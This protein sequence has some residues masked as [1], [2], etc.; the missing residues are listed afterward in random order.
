[1]I[2]AT[3]EEEIKAK[4]EHA[5]Q[6]AEDTLAARTAFLQMVGHELRTPLNAVL[7]P[8]SIASF[9]ND[10][11]ERQ[12]M[13]TVA[14]RSA[15]DL[16]ATV[17]ALEDFI[18]LEA[19][20]TKPKLEETDL[21]ELLELATIEAVN[22]ADAPCDVPI[23]FKAGTPN[24]A[25]CDPGIIKWVVKEIVTNALQHANPM[26][27]EER[28][29]QI[30]VSLDQSGNGEHIS[31]A[32][33]DNGQG[34]ADEEITSALQPF[35]RLGQLNTGKIRGLGIGLALAKRYAELLK[36]SLSYQHG[37]QGGSTF[38]ITLPV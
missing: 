5:K 13:I 17:S 30:N 6:V 28:K 26:G 22:Q 31:I 9:T 23:K 15:N 12:A 19:G 37:H 25:H 18:A 29:V 21:K 1:M 2:D 3:A 34:I 10:P 20:E 27:D 4:L 24:S 11:V 16:T 7:G 32:I 35:T 33:S 38:V 8:L 14:E 36:G